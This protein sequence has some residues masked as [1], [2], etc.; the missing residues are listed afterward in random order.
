MNCSELRWNPDTA[1]KPEKSPPVQGRYVAGGK[2]RPGDVHIS[3]P[4]FPS[5]GEP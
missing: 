3:R 4:L 5:I 2:K 1:R